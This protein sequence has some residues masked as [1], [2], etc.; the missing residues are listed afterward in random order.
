MSG[1]RCEG[2]FWGGDLTWP[3][4]VE[5]VA[6]D[7]TDHGLHVNVNTTLICFFPP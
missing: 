1:Q 7:I 6:R 2:V 5:L 3:P 4:L